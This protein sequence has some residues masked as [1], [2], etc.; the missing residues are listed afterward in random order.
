MLTTLACSVCGAGQDGTEWAYLAMTGVVS[1]TPLAMIGG[2][3]FWLYR[4]SKRRE[5]ED[6]ARAEALDPRVAPTSLR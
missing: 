6:A 1:L 4:A 5:A 2:V 3:A